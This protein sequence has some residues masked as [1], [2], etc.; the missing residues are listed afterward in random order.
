MESAAAPLLDALRARATAAYIRLAGATVAADELLGWI[1]DLAGAL[2]DTPFDLESG[3]IVA[4]GGLH[5]RARI[6]APIDCE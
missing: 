5:P 3:H 1:H 4:V 6:A 2:R